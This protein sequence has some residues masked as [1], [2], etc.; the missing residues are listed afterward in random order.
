MTSHQ[1]DQ[2]AIHFLCVRPHGADP[3]PSTGVHLSLSPSTPLRGDVINGWPHML[4]C[5][6]NSRNNGRWVPLQTLQEYPLMFINCKRCSLLPVVF[7]V[8]RWCTV[9]Q[10][11]IFVQSAS[12]KIIEKKHL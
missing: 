6:A 5:M 7:Y 12:Y 10:H 9:R 8:L 4:P 1:S 11:S 3:S 2:W